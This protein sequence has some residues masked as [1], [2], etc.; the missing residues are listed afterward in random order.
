MPAMVSCLPTQALPSDNMRFITLGI[1]LL[2]FTNTAHAVADISTIL[3][4]LRGII[5]PLT[6]LVLMICFIGGGIMIFH[7]LTMLKKIGQMSTMQSQPGELGKP[8]IYMIVGTMLIYIPSTTGTLLNSLFETGQS[9]FGGGSINYQAMGQGASLLQYGSAN[10]V[11]QQWTDFANTLVLFIQFGGFL[12]FVKGWFIISHAGGQGAQQGS[13]ARGITH[14]IA[15][16]ILINFVGM[17]NIIANTIFGT[18]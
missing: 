7:A 5:V 18:G 17:A 9:I 3:A 8:L 1:I 2:F 11:V 4:N 12:S 6:G 15:G 16:I 13:I 14:I 10:S